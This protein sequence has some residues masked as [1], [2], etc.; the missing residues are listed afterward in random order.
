LEK[1]Q[2]SLPEAEQA[3]LYQAKGATLTAYS[4]DMQYAIVDISTVLEAFVILQ[5][6]CQQCQQG[7][8][9]ILEY[10]MEGH[11]LHVKFQCL[12]CGYEWKWCGSQIYKDS[13]LKVNRDIVVAWKTTGNERGKYFQFT[14]AMRC[15]QYNDNSWDKTVQLLYPIVQDTV[16]KSYKK[17]VDYINQSKEG[18]II[19][20]DVQH[21][22]SQRASGSAPFAGCVFMLH[23]KGPY[24][25]WII[26]Q[27]LVSNSGLVAAGKQKN[28]SK[29]KHATHFGLVKV[30]ELLDQIQHGICDG[31]SSANKSWREVIQTNP[32]FH[33]PPISNCFWHKAKGISSK[34]NSELVDKKVLLLKDQR[35]GNKIYTLKYPQFQ[36]WGITGKKIKSVFYQ[37]Q[38]LWNGNA[39][40][41]AEE[42]IGAAEYYKFMVDQVIT[43]QEEGL[44]D[45]TMEV[46]TNWLTNFSTS[47]HKYCHGYLTDIEESFHRVVNKYWKKGN[48]SQYEEYELARNLACLDWNENVGKKGGHRTCYFR[49]DICDTFDKMMSCK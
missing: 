14:E 48:S 4:F 8:L 20:C 45:E 15:G 27:Q 18:A 1:L 3:A 10:W 49:K 46:F 16:N 13:S 5:K 28:E 23:N 12:E 30:A 29:D 6:G 2:T 41:M 35:K 7:K 33:K 42:F 39:E 11:G 34:F 43:D 32:K 40:E 22:R 25:S 19:G 17:G 24:Y 31:S 26:H 36:Q 47:F 21:S 44:S 37:A 38:K 9:Y